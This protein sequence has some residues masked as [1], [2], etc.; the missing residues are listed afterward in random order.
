MRLLLLVPLLLLPAACRDD[1]H[2]ESNDF[3][4][5]DEDGVCDAEDACDGGDDSLDADGDGVPDACDAELLAS[6]S[7][8]EVNLGAP[9]EELR[10]W[11][12]Y[13]AT[14]SLQSWTRIDPGWQF[15]SS[16]LRTP[17]SF[18]TFAVSGWTAFEEE[19]TDG[20]NDELAIVIEGVDDSS[21]RVIEKEREEA[22]RLGSPDLQ[23]RE[24][25]RIDVQIRTWRTDVNSVVTIEFEY[26]GR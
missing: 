23:G 13:N 26:Y 12:A 21:V 1:C 5:V 24:V 9:V 19:L 22:L 18:E 11:L 3:V 6:F 4:D 20:S 7:V 25:T 17:R 15:T 16:E 2:P 10:V 14:G 8:Q